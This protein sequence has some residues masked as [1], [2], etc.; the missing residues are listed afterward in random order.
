MA[1]TKHFHP[2]VT[3]TRWVEVS[4]IAKDGGYCG[5]TEGCPCCTC[6]EDGVT[7]VMFVRNRWSRSS[8][9]WQS[10]TLVYNLCSNHNTD[11]GPW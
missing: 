6:D 1:R 11:E 3:C 9:E 7:Q 4:R 5:W 2:E 10:E 8:R